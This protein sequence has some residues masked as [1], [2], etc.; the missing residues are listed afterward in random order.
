LPV[1]FYILQGPPNRLDYIPQAIFSA[2]TAFTNRATFPKETQVDA[3]DQV[4]NPGATASINLVLATD[5]DGTLLAGTQEARRRIRDL[6][7]GGLL[8]ARLI[9]VTG[10][11]LESITPLL[12]DSKLPQPDYIIA[13]V[14]ATVVHGDLR[15]VDPLHHEI[16]GHWPGTQV[17]LQQLARFPLLQRQTVPQERRCSFFISEGGISAELRAAVD[18][19]DCDLLFSAG[20]YLDV[21]PRGINKGAT[22]RRL[23]EAEGFDLD[24]IVVAGDTLNDLSMFATGFK[25]IVVGGA[26]PELVQRVRKMP[27]VFVAQDE[28]CGGI[29]AGLAHHGTQVDSTPK[30]QRRM[31]ERGDA[32]LVMVYHRPPFDEVMEDGVVKQ[33][34][35]KSPN[36]IIPT[37]LGFFAGERKGSWVA[38]SMQDSRTPE[39]FVRHVPVDAK[40]Y[41]RLKVARI[42]LTPEDVDIF[43]KKFSKEA[44]WPII[45]SF[46]DKAEFNQAHWERFLEVNRIFAEQTARE[47]AEGAVVWIHDYNLWM[48]PAYLRPLRPDLRIAF[49]HHTAFPASDIF[50]I[51]P[52]YREIIGSLL[53][54][55]HIGFHIP[56]YVENFV[57]A[58]RSY[59]PVEVLESVPCAPRF[60]TYG[61]ALGV[62]SVTSAI[63][64]GGHRVT[65]GAHPVGIDV[66]LV[67]QTL[68]KPAVQKKI[69]RIEALL[70]GVQGIVSIERLDYVKGS[71]EKLQAFERLLEDHPE[72][73]GGVTLLNIITPA[74]P[75]MEIYET[76]RTEVDRI[77]GRINGRFST[78]EWT[79]VLYFYRSLP[80]ESVIAYYAACDVAWITPLRDGL[81]L[82]A[83][84]F[85]ATKKVTGTTGVL[86]LSEFAGAA[87]ELHGALLTNPYDANSMSKVLHQ[88]LTMGAD[89]AA[90]RCQRMAAIVAENDVVRW[91]NEFMDAVQAT[92]PRGS[93]T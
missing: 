7:S 10:R 36:G 79:P 76:L 18:A 59:T 91:G 57:D 73:V 11:G 49:F 66:G 86:I 40:R 30:A 65:L 19:L 24:A 51:L 39:G 25:G 41:P 71:M 81:N 8:G 68:K 75:G 34:R 14:G 5:L 1:L 27:R 84:E 33:K 48:V 4:P 80:F 9:Y 93:G 89:E 32:E 78:L 70:H 47:A 67:E 74:A 28:G 17:I 38:W 69:A 21:L 31:D 23:A 56:R 20:R 6:F 61:C 37:L 15:P 77:V 50:N 90:Y 52:W 13:D 16:A 45:F 83:K 63:D 35:P 46:P 29:L 72:L 42:A 87:V 43:Y 3:I 60:I 2:V 58:V 54:C 88:A 53:Q 62:D 22:L 26:E 92:V 82:V 44:F 85:V 64:V 12:S 55:D